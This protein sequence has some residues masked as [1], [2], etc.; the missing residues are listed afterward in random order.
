MHRK[1][2][3]ALLCQLARSRAV[4]PGKGGKPAEMIGSFPGGFACHRKVQ[5]PADGLSNFSELNSLFRHPV[6]PGLRRKRLLQRKSVKLA[7][8]EPMQGGPAI[9][10][11]A[12]VRRHALFT[13]RV[14]EN[15]N[16][17]VIAIAVD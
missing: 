2:A 10:S 6:K 3:K 12:D 15:W 13:G 17:A 11:F 1:P 9:E 8:I 16:K 7:G 14:D 5:P 4:E